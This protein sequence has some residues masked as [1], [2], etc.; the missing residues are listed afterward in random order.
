MGIQKIQKTILI[1][2]AILVTSE[3]ISWVYTQFHNVAGIFSSV[4]VAI[5]VMG[6]YWY[7]GKKACESAATTTWFI[8]PCTLF[9]AIPLAIRLWPSE[10][11]EISSWQAFIAIIPFL[12]SFVLPIVLLVTVYLQLSHH[13]DN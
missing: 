2:I 5:F 3:I 9:T 7:C 8:L 4:F 11:E 13:R 12:V 6:I 1:I 10:T